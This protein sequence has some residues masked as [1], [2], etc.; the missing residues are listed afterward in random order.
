MPSGRKFNEMHEKNDQY[1]WNK[2]SNILEDRKKENSNR[3][4]STYKQY[5]E[6]FVI[7]PVKKPK[8]KD[9]LGK[10]GTKPPPVKKH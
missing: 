5:D 10:I 2:Y 6:S 3:P 9:L 4:L 8:E 1:L 7:E